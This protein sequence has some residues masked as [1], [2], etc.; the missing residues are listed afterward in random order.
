VPG[1]LPVGPVVVS[2]LRG[3]VPRVILSARFGDLQLIVSD[4]WWACF[5]ANLEHGVRGGGNVVT[6]CLSL[7]CPLGAVGGRLAQLMLVPRRRLHGLV[8][9]SVRVKGSSGGGA[10]G[11]RSG[12]TGS[13]GCVLA[14][15]SLLRAARQGRREQLLDGT[16]QRPNR[17]LPAGSIGSPV[18][19]GGSSS[20]SAT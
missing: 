8:I 13:I 4:G 15:W 2:E 10:G 7:S 19:L 14:L 5:G 6:V 20:C 18:G 9:D 16:T 11:G 12:W 3:R 17:S 1:Q